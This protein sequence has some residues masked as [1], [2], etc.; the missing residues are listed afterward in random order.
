MERLPASVR[1]SFTEEQLSGLKVALAAR[2]WGEHAIDWRGTLRWFRYRYYFVFLL[3]RNR[4]SLTRG[5]QQVGLLVQAIG[6][7]L[8]LGFSTLLGLL[9]LY[10]AKSAAGIDLFPGFSLGIWGWFKG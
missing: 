8:F 1:E 9:A 2:R 3:G 10:L 6:T 5:E 7:L 4:R